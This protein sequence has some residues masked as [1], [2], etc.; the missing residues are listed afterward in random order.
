MS[1]PGVGVSLRQPI[2][3]SDVCNI[4]TGGRH[5]LQPSS[6]ILLAFFFNAQIPRTGMDQHIYDSSV[7][8]QD[9]GQ[10]VDEASDNHHGGPSYAKIHASEVLSDVAYEDIDRTEWHA[11]IDGTYPLEGGF[12]DNLSPGNSLDYDTST[13]ANEE[14]FEIQQSNEHGDDFDVY[15][16]CKCNFFDWND[17]PYTWQSTF[18][19][20]LGMPRLAKRRCRICRF[21][22][23]IMDAQRLPENGLWDLH[24][25]GTDSSTFNSLV[26]AI[27]E[28]GA[29]RKLDVL[30]IRPSF[31]IEEKPG[32]ST[33]ERPFKAAPHLII[34]NFPLKENS[35]E[36]RYYQANHVNF[37]QIRGWMEDC[38]MNHSECCS[39]DVH[40][41]L[42]QLRVIDCGSNTVVP[43]PV[44]CHY[45]ALSY[46]W[47]QQNDA[48]DELQNPPKTIADS[49]YL[50]QRLGYEYLW[51]DRFV[52]SRDF[53]F[54]STGL[55]AVV[56]RSERSCG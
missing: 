6:S 2:N 36:K 20:T 51:I 52:C 39:G 41:S 15:Q 37:D 40:H 32:Q 5:L 34:A 26:S 53:P 35:V 23:R 24:L 33:P 4:W 28:F 19:V 17:L 9:F 31:K 47:G 12:D 50:T 44:G 18:R 49:I 46:V 1:L 56:Y 11:L 3:Q 22:G 29:D 38:F 54:H 21:I 16:Q 8:E 48:F 42:R 45:V 7:T 25:S 55:T 30:Q 10:W 27:P 14:Y 13:S 43:A